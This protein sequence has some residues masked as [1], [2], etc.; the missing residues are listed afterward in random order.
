MLKRVKKIFTRIKNTRRRTKVIAIIIALVAFF[1]LNRGGGKGAVLEY[2]VLAKGDINAQVSASG[3]LNG[4]A[5]A[6]LHFNQAG[7]LSYLPFGD[8][9][10]VYRGQAVA[11]LDTTALNAAYSQ[12]LN[13]RRNTQAAVDAIHDQVK[14]HSG[15]ET[16][17]Q[18]AARTQAE[19]TNDSA[20]DGVLAAQKA[21]RDATLTSPING[22][23]V[24]SG[25]LSVGQNI[26]PSDVI[27]QI[28]DFSKKVFEAKVDESDIGSI[29]VGQA[30]NVTLNAYGSTVFKGKVI[31]IEPITQT[32]TTGAIT[33]TVK[34]EVDDSRIE[35]IYGLNGN[36][37]IIIAA[38]SGVLVVPQDAL[39][40]DT[41]LYVKCS[42]CKTGVEKRQIETGI[43]SDTQVEVISGVS[44]GDQVVT[45][46]QVVK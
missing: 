11:K 17:A 35:S 20:W 37:D 13:T 14:D 22:I 39:L 31:E 19:A 36:A 46:P 25:N 34:I 41:H 44:E 2:A 1:F 21:L 16:F 10:K 12:A 6:T 45:N 27:Y 40:D 32:D 26:G 18:K 43:K 8:G 24:A 29:K 28:V 30:A 42:A 4:K 33:V 15:D 3:Q 5:L 38:K 23:I 9:T 7:K